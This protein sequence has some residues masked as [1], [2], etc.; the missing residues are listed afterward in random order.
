MLNNMRKKYNDM[1][2]IIIFLLVLLKTKYPK[3][4]KFNTIPKRVDKKIAIDELQ[5][6]KIKKEK[7]EYPNSVFIVPI[8]TKRIA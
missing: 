1:N 8:K 3:V 7:R 6:M 5:C 2:F 4:L